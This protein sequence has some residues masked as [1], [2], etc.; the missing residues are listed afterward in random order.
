[1]NTYV[2]NRF[3]E[4][5]MGRGMSPT[6][7]QNRL[8]DAEDEIQ[9]MIQMLVSTGRLNDDGAARLARPYKAADA[10][11]SS[12]AAATTPKRVAAGALS[13]DGSRSK[14]RVGPPARDWDEDA[15]GAWLQ[16][17]GLGQHA[18]AFAHHRIDGRLL[19]QLE[20]ADLGN[21]LGVSSRLERKRILSQ[22]ERLQEEMLPEKAR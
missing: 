18:D 11:S 15:V 16:A 12:A 2:K 20:D 5:A 21:E 22:V 9:R 6:A 3:R 8:T 10:S 19:L 14:P 13:G 7:V 17:L 1:M 4:D